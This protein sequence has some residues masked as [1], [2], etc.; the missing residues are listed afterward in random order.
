MKA[1]LALISWKRLVW[2]FGVNYDL[3][4]SRAAKDAARARHRGKG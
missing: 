2:L 4:Y 1:S 3:H